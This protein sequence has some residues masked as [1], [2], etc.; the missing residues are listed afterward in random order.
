MK[1][2]KIVSPVAHFFYRRGTFMHSAHQM[3]RIRGCFVYHAFVYA[4]LS[5]RIFFRASAKSDAKQGYDVHHTFM[6][7]YYRE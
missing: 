5:F 6:L 7:L 1:R 3:P 2:G 4:V